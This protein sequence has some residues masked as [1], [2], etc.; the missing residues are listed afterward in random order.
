M[1]LEMPS[2]LRH[3]MVCCQV[4]LAVKLEKAVEKMNI[5]RACTKENFVKSNK[6]N[7]VLVMADLT[8]RF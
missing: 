3:I 5:M 2:A 1:F 8:C 4:I 6:K 7:T